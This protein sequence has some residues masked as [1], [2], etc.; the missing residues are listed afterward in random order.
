M[1]FHNFKA[2]LSAYDVHFSDSDPGPILRAVFEVASTHKIPCLR[3]PPSPMPSIPNSLPDEGNLSLQPP[4]ASAPANILL[5]FYDGDNG[6]GD[7]TS[8]I[9]SEL[10]GEADDEN[11]EEDDCSDHEEEIPRKIY[12]IGLRIF[13]K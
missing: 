5:D 7:E 1:G 11:D 6:K 8:N 10:G 3:I 12:G 4:T 13:A 9:C 2:A